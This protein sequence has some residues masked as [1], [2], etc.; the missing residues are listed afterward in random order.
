MFVVSF[1][2]FFFFEKNVCCQLLPVCGAVVPLQ[3][4]TM[5]GR[6]QSDSHKNGEDIMKPI[7]VI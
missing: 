7:N 2:F 3:R 1:S 4:P 5:Y 6:R